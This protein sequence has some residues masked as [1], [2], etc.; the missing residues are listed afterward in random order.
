M[1]SVGRR[2]LLQLSHCNLEDAGEY[3]CDAGDCRA[4]AKLRVFGKD[5]PRGEGL[6]WAQALVSFS[7]TFP[8]VYWL[9]PIVIVCL[10]YLPDSYHL[11]PGDG[12]VIIATAVSQRQRFVL[13][14]CTGS[15]M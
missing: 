10:S 9:L 12:L 1:Y 2:R 11:C 6:G 7:H 8:L 15:L 14:A 4:S 13:D 3:T 5:N